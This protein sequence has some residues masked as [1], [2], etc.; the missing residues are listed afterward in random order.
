MLCDICEVEA[1]LGRVVGNF[2]VEG[3]A[4]ARVFDEVETLRKAKYLAWVRRLESWW[5]V[6]IAIPRGLSLSLREV[7][8]DLHAREVFSTSLSPAL[9]SPPSAVSLR[10]MSRLPLLSQLY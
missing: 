8:T 5:G 6:G 3:V 4:R 10:L 1:I 2:R 9:F 7:I